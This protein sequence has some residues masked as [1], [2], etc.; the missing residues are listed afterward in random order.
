MDERIPNRIFQ[1]R[2]VRDFRI[3]VWVAWNKDPTA[4]D[5]I[6]EITARRSGCAC[7]LQRNFRIDT[8]DTVRCYS[9]E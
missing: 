8:V 9:A 3:G 6:I 1:L 4:R 5:G 2:K 7:I